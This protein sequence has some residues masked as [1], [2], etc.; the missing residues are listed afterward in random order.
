MKNAHML[1][2]LRGAL[3]LPRILD[4]NILNMCSELSGYYVQHIKPDV[5][6]IQ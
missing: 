2:T 4:V 6:Y 5:S 3:V 1:H